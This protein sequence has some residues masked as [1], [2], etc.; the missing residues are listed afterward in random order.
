MTQ[1]QTVQ[2]KNQNPHP[3]VIGVGTHD[4]RLWRQAWI[5]SVIA[6]ADSRPLAA[7]IRQESTQTLST[8]GTP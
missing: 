8:R 4:L 2:R 5:R 3:P 6:S 7:Y 1:N